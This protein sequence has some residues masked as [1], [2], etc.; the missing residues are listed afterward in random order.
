MLTQPSANGKHV[1]VALLEAFESPGFDLAR[2]GVKLGLIGEDAAEIRWVATLTSTD[3]GSAIGIRTAI[4]SDDGAFIAV[5]AWNYGVAVVD[6]Q[7]GEKLWEHMPGANAVKYAAFSPDAKTVY[8]GGTE[9]IIYAMDTLTGNV[10]GK[11]Y[12]SE[13]GREQDGNPIQCLA[14]SP[15]GR[16]VAAGTGPAGLVFVG[17]TATNKMVRVLRHGGSTVLLVHFSPDSSALASFV[18][19]TLKIWKVA[20]W[21]DRKP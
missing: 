12:A 3:A 4:A 11:W 16:W 15:D 18:P 8:A 13:S 17:S 14:V 1:A 6:T 10:L 2:Q 5:A 21:D 7:T 19:G 9:G 20:Q